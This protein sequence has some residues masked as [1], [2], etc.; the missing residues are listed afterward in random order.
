MLRLRPHVSHVSRRA[1]AVAAA[2]TVPSPLSALAHSF[3]STT[4]T[5]TTQD[6]TH[7]STFFGEQP[8][9]R[10]GWLPHQLTV[11]REETHRGRFMAASF[12]NHLALGSAFT[13]SMWVPALTSLQGIVVPSSDDWL[14]G[15]VTPAF[16][17]VMGG[18]VW[19]ALTGGLQQQIGAR[20][21]CLIGAFGLT[22]GFALTALAAS[23]HDLNLLYAA[24]VVTGLGNGFAYVPPVSCLMQWFPDRK[25]LASGTAIA[26]YGCSSIVTSFLG[27]KLLN[28]YEEA[29]TYVGKVEELTMTSEGGKLFVDHAEVVV[30]TAKDVA[31]WASYGLEEGAYLVGTGSTGITETL[32]T[33]GCLYGSI[34]TLASLQYRYPS[35]EVDSGPTHSPSTQTDTSGTTAATAPST[36]PSRAITTFNVDTTVA[37]TSKQFWLMYTGFG[38]AATGAYGFI[39]AG[40][41]MVG[42][43]FGPVITPA[44]AAAFVASMGVGN[45]AGRVGWTLGSDYFATLVKGVPVLRAAGDDPFLGRKMA[46][47]MMFTVPMILYPTAYWC[48][49]QDPSQF[50]LFLFTGSVLGVVSSF[51]GMAATRPALCADVWGLKNGPGVLSARQLSVVLPAALAGPA[52][53]SHFRGEASHE[54]IVD[55]VGKCQDQEF[56]TTFMASKD[57]LEELIEAK[58]V[59]INRLLEICPSGTI[60]PTPYLYDQA[61]MVMGALGVGALVTN[62][63]LHPMDPSSHEGFEGLDMDKDERLDVDE[64]GSARVVRALDKDGDG[65]VNKEE[66]EKKHK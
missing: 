41:T 48:V 23:T 12:S 58:T 22:S 16:S 30:A 51:G 64:L 52:I 32:L 7:K 17:L 39:G 43:C 57:H 9:A 46:F 47:S 10:L 18:F 59:T 8:L 24:G 63:L 13:F 40:K 44:F 29:P 56:E 14:L 2:T 34:M 1:V 28:H 66:F 11:D 61:L 45:L 6:N 5:T 55:L 36:A 20:A 50:T 4:T 26:G 27:Y 25:G 38:L 49:H 62:A 33:I 3:S 35:M 15:D 31:K 37:T 54:A 65:V 19:G 60:D 42:E 21:S 53:V